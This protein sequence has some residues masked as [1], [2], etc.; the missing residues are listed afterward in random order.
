MI[1][2]AQWAGSGKV[3]EKP[4][5]DF[6]PGTWCP[7]TDLAVVAEH[8]DLV[9]P[10]CREER[11]RVHVSEVDLLDPL[12]RIGRLARPGVEGETLAALL[13]AVEQVRRRSAKTG[14]DKSMLRIASLAEIER[15]QIAEDRPLPSG[16]SLRPDSS[17]G[18]SSA[19]PCGSGL[20]KPIRSC[21]P[22]LRQG[23]RC[24]GRP[25]ASGSIACLLA[26]L[27]T[28]NL[29]SAAMSSISRV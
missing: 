10:G 19:L 23:L 11:L 28:A 7:C 2:T 24:S 26:V 29:G 12:R 5:N 25:A 27:R 1:E 15:N 9:F 14:G 20:R 17:G 6:S 18:S 22:G 4:R 21:R 8:I 16:R 13:A 3:K